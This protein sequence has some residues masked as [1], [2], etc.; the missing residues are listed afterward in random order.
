VVGRTSAE[1]VHRFIEPLQRAL[2]CVTD[3]VIH[4]SRGYFP[5]DEPHGA[6]LSQNP[7]VLRTSGPNSIYL[8]VTTS[9]V[10]EH[11]DGRE[12][13]RVRIAGHT[14]A[15]DDS[16]YREILAYHWHPL[17]VSAVT[18]PHLHLG[19]GALLGRDDLMMAHLPTGAVALADVVRLAIMDFG[20]VPRR[21]DWAKVLQESR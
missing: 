7:A 16:S 5:R 8:F 18:T 3:A 4:V 2:S 14:F 13:W 12:P 1:A 9:Y 19:P 10:I 15:L 20:V 17:G 6:E 11:T 21:D